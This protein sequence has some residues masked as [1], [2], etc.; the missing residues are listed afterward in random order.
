M[1][2]TSDAGGTTPWA[3]WP[4]HVFSALEKHQAS[5]DALRQDFQRMEI[6]VTELVGELR[7][8]KEQLAEAKAQILQL[9]TGRELAELKSKLGELAQAKDLA[10]TRVRLEAA[11]KA[12]DQQV[13]DFAVLK[14]RW[15]LIGS[16]AVIFGGAIGAII[17]RLLTG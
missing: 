9:A 8:V 2:A 5:L 10:D 6:K 1:T 4:R 7:S 13:T 14:G 11:E 3:E 17:V 16:I 15:L 12:L